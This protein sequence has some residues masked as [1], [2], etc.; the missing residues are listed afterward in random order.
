MAS[1]DVNGVMRQVC[2]AV[3]GGLTDP[4]LLDCFLEHRDE[5]AFEALVRRHGPMVLGVCRRVLQNLHDAEDAFQAT[6]LVLAR[7]ASTI[8][9]KEMVGNWLYGVAYRTALKARAASAKRKA[10]ERQVTDMP[11]RDS[12]EP[13]VPLWHELQPLLDQELNHLPDKYRVPVVLC[14]LEGKTRKEAAE[15][16][17]WPEGT[18]SWRLAS[19]R[20]ALAKR[21]TRHGLVLS[22]GSL[23]LVLS[24]NTASAAVP[25]P[26]VAS[27]VKAAALSGLG[28][29]VTAGVISANVAALTEGVLTTMFV[30]KVKIA[31]AVLLALTVLGTGV[32]VVSYQ[33]ATGQDNGRRAAAPQ[34]QQREATGREERRR[35]PDFAGKITA[36]SDDGKTLTLSSGGGRGQEQPKNVDLKLTDK[37]QVEFTGLLKNIAKKLKVGDTAQVWLQEGSKDTAGVIHATKNADISAKITAVSADGK[38]L[39]VETPGPGRGEVTKTDIKITDKTKIGWNVRGAAEEQKPQ[40]GYMA[41]VWFEE[42][43]KDTAAALALSRPNPNAI[44]EISAVTK[45]L[46]TL[47]TKTRSGDNVKVEIKITPQ[48]KIES[49]GANKAELT[50]GLQAMVWYMEGST[51][52]AATVHVAPVPRGSPDASGRIGAISADGKSIT[53]ENQRRGEDTTTKTEIKLSDKTRVE[54]LGTDKKEEEKLTVGYNTAV[55]FE[56]GSKDTAAVIQ[57]TKP[58]ERGR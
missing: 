22:A 29:A 55:W 42:G 27:T 1:G 53:L 17:G 38:V 6:F 51:D 46:L 28:Q 40:V 5:R 36:I 49:V 52:T 9:P 57:A 13:R 19:A 12:Q 16:L 3:D 21:L 41:T 31:A 4:Q 11:G 50:V 15:Q 44:G 43:S 18:L 56:K 7:K 37:T 33:T 47:D 30:A 14:D 10:K 48:T 54:Y 26:L 58:K 35:T 2:R 23:A 32:G 45:D 8:V 39:S 24:Q 20:E 25:L 34:N